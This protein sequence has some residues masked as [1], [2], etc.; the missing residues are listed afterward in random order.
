MKLLRLVDIVIKN[1]GGGKTII[2]ECGEIIYGNILNLENTERF[3]VEVDRLKSDGNHP[4][5]EILIRAF[6]EL[7]NK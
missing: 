4:D 2:C 6:Q 5:A 7:Q 1:H 3:L